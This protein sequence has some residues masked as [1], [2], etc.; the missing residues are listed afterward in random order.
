MRY[1]L[2]L[3]R[4][5]NQQIDRLPGNVR[6]RVRRTIAS[7]VFEPRP[8]NAEEL[9]EELTGL[10]RIKLDDYRIIYSIDEDAITVEVIR[11]AKRTPR[12]Y[13]GLV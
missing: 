9:A 12:T 4:A 2:K 13:A 1:R 5:L 10:W 6:Q 8:E 3:S 11:V 7:L